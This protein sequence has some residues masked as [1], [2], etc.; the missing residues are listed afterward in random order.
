MNLIPGKFALQG[1]DK[2][3]IIRLFASKSKETDSTYKA[4]A[5]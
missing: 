2:I 3:N 5:F 4:G 1:C